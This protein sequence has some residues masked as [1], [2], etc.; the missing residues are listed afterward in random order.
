M[1]SLDGLTWCE[2]TDLERLATLIP[3]LDARV[4]P[5]APDRDLARRTLARTRVVEMPF[6]L[7]RNPPDGRMHDGHVVLKRG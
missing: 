3:R 7:P 6:E 5:M 2:M 4:S 1:R